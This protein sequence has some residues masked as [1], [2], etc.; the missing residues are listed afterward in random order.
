[1][2]ME[3]TL[4]LVKSAVDEEKKLRE[5]VQTFW[6]DCIIW[7]LPVMNTKVFST[8]IF[9]ILVVTDKRKY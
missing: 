6:K 9:K 4:S 7:N 2:A 8:S 1:M 3:G 5:N